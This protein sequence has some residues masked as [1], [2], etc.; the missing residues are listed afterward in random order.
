VIAV[1][2]MQLVE[3]GD[4]DLDA[5][6]GD[7][8][9][10][11]PRSLTGVTVRHLLCHQSGLPHYSNGT[12]TST[13]EDIPL[14][15]Q[16]DPDESIKRFLNSQLL[17]TPG[18]KTD[19]SSY[20]YVLLSSVVQSA[21][22]ADIDAQLKKRITRPLRLNS[23]QLDFPF[24]QQ[25]NWTFAYRVSEDG[26]PE[27]ISDTA[28]FWKHGAG[29]YKSDIEDFAKWSASLMSK[30]LLRLKTTREMWTAQ[31]TA[32][33]QPTTRGLGFIVGGSAR[34]LKISHNGNGAV[35]Q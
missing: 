10:G 27:R 24:D 8:V 2:A 17:F 21:G 16:T 34:S 1:M 29:A 6:V 35:S 4:L 11:L 7:Y 15:D 18:T 12:V 20:A 14:M 26:P 31:K 5:S 25:P 30:K 13:G 22:K 32:D 28:H 33:G 19:Y 23:F 3:S 9:S